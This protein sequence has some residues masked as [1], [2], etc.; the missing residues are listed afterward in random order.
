MSFS[1]IFAILTGIFILFLAIYT[2]GKLLKTGSYVEATTASQQLSI[3]FDPLDTTFSGAESTSVNMQRQVRITNKCFTDGAFGKQEFSVTGSGKEQ[4][5]K[6][7]TYH[8][9][10]FS[11]DVLD[12]KTLNFITTPVNLPFL[13]ASAVSMYAENYCFVSPPSEIENEIK[14]LSLKNII[15]ANSDGECSDKEIR[16]CFGRQCEISVFPL[17]TSAECGS[18]YEEGYAVKKNKRVYYLKG[19]FFPAIISSPEVYECVVKRIEM[20]AQNLAVLYS[21]QARRMSGMCGE[22]VESEYLG[23]ANSLRVIGSSEGLLS[24]GLKN[25][26]RRVETNNEGRCCI[27]KC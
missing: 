14:Q 17:C 2:G 5:V 22:L 3:L 10:V 26:M 19:L 11:N 8:K 23:L 6:A 20:R 27:W 25:A 24:A 16:V 12:G 1:W 4:G 15:I 7:K 21:E 9:H 13:S 18:E